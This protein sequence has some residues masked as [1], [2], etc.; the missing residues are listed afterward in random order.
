MSLQKEI[1][2]MNWWANAKGKPEMKINSLSDDDAQKI[3][4][5]IDT[6]LSPE[7]LY[8][9]G[10]ISHSAAQAKYRAYHNAIKELNKRGFVARD[11]YEF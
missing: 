2:E 10:E 6:G 4:V 3:Y 5:H 11:C 1:N 9:D 7:N 8:C